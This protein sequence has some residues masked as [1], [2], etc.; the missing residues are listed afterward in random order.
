VG[1]AA[2]GASAEGAAAVDDNLSLHLSYSVAVTV[3]IVSCGVR[4]VALAWKFSSSPRLL[5]WMSVQQ[6]AYHAASG[7]RSS[8]SLDSRMSMVGAGDER[9]ANDDEV[10]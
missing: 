1:V 10:K 7:G 5:P 6:L 2:E 4:P 9:T 3:D 8:T